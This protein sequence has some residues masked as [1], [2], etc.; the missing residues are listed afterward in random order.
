VR[1][2]LSLIRLVQLPS[3]AAA[4]I[5]SAL[6][7]M[8]SKMMLH[9]VVMSVFA[10]LVAPF[11]GFFAS[12]FKRA[13]KIKDF[14]DA[15]PGHGGFTDRM[16]CQ[17]V[18]GAFAYVYYNYVVNPTGVLDSVLS[19]ICRLTPQELVCAPLPRLLLACAVTANCMLSWYD[20]VGY[21]NCCNR[22]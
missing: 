16:D 5:P 18:I 9:A 6:D 10:S 4:L 22:N 8:T 3:A 7:V 14:S 12:G 21:R 17:I 11:G 1:L 13:F 20:I 2:R 15:I 19:S